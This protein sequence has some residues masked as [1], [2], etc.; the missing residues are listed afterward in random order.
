MGRHSKDPELT[1][2]ANRAKNLSFIPFEGMWERYR[3][4]V[5][6]Q[7]HPHCCYLMPDGVTWAIRIHFCGSF[8]TLGYVTG[9]VVNAM[10]F[11][12]MAQVHFYKYKQRNALEPL[13]ENL[14]Y[15]LAQAKHDLEHEPEAANL[16]KDLEQYLLERGYIP[17]HEE[18]RK[19]REARRKNAEAQRAQRRTVSGRM[20]EMFKRIEEKILQEIKQCYT[21]IASHIQSLED[22]IA[23]M[24][25]ARVVRMSEFD[26]HKREEEI[27]KLSDLAH[28][29]PQPVPTWIAKENASLDQ[30]QS[31]FNPNQEQKQ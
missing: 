6:A 21:V 19:E 26:E 8:R 28:P 2:L 3:E 4:M 17:K 10:R 14:N 25:V 9:K 31:I 13:D 27:K 20:D 18:I 1:K 24:E 16:L 29:H 15:S 23:R 12:D 30:L 22:R 11:A 5:L 7:E